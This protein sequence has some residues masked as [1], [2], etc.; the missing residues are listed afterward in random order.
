MH[1]QTI[2]Y[3]LDDEDSF[4]IGTSHKHRYGLS[5]EN[6]SRMNAVIHMNLPCSFLIP[7]HIGSFYDSIIVVG[8]METQLW[9]RTMHHSHIHTITNHI[10]ETVHVNSRSSCDSFDGFLLGIGNDLKQELTTRSTYPVPVLWT[11][12]L[13]PHHNFTNQMNVLFLIHFFQ[14]NL[15]C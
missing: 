11:L 4:D 14:I 9:I 5:H 12:L 7:N 6:K 8:T 3:R 10:I 13:I 15:I 1:G 2:H